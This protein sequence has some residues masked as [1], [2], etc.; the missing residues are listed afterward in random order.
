MAM[1]KFQVLNIICNSC[2]LTAKEKLVAQYF[3]YKS[4]QAGICYP[5][6]NTIAKQCGASERTIQRATK[7]L[8]EKG[9]IVI[10]KRSINGRQT[11]NEYVL[12]VNDMDRLV[13]KNEVASAPEEITSI[14]SC[15]M[16]LVS[17]E[18]YINEAKADSKEKNE[19]TA[20]NGSNASADQDSRDKV[21]N[22]SEELIKGEAYKQFENN[23][24]TPNRH[25][26]I[27]I[28]RKKENYSQVGQWSNNLGTKSKEAHKISYYIFILY[29]L[30][31]KYNFEKS[32]IAVISYSDKDKKQIID[33]LRDCNLM[34]FLGVPP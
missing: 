24:N 30:I 16:K 13:M 23:K 31:I 7:K 10:N 2:E 32:I 12:V 14:N 6:V 4:N 1:K 5:S 20:R 11:S 18:N 9:Y 34:L 22:V 27:I 15:D 8:Q 29:K 21:S 33:C 28:A 17:F 25:T 26:K 3:V 19:I